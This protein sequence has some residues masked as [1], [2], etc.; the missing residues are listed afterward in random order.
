MLIQ[1]KHATRVD[2][3]L[4]AFE[5]VLKRLYCQHPDLA[6]ET[7]TSAES[8]ADLLGGVIEPTSTLSE[9]AFLNSGADVALVRHLRYLPAIRHTH[10]FIEVGLLLAGTCV[11][12]F[13][14]AEITMVAGDVCIVAPGTVHAISAFTDECHLVNVLIRA[15]TFDSAFA[16]IAT[17]PHPSVGVFLRPAAGTASPDHLHLRVACG[18]DV[19]GYLDLL[20]NEL[21]RNSGTA[22]EPF[23][24]ELL[25]STAMGL[26]ISLLRR[27]KKAEFPVTTESALSVRV[28]RLV[29][30][31][32]ST[33]TLADL[34]DHLS[35]SERHVQRII[36]DQFG[37][38]F[39]GLVQRERMERAADLLARTV[40]PV[41]D[42]A[43]AVGYTD[44]SN[45]RR[46]FG[47]HY[48]TTPSRHRINSRC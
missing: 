38:T 48:A 5:Q 20:Q 11:N 27:A 12:S 16:A 1:V 34:A 41:S 23:H 15:S 25:N 24:G 40:A 17:D 3:A 30:E 46:L 14:D 2:P 21:S 18:A 32:L 22:L 10:E 7:P 39:I 6:L 42:V 29:R 47:R 31:N 45:F 36:W 35:Y 8:V 37:T 43:R 33:I 19:L 28:L 26:I 4:N 44:V 13:D 9:A